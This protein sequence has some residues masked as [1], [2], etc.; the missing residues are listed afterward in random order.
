M[1]NDIIFQQNYQKRVE[2]K[3]N[4]ALMIGYNRGIQQMLYIIERMEKSNE[5]VTFQSVVECI[6]KEMYEH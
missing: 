6:K 1:V 2:E 5:K 4:S 3:I